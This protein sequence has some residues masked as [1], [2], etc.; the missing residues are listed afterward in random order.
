M[1]NF[2]VDMHTHSTA[3]DGTLTP[4]D[5]VALAA[6]RGVR[7]LGLCDHD[8]TA[9]LDEAIAAG[10][11]RGLTV[12]P[13]VEISTR[14]NRAKQ[15]VGLHLL[16]Y[17]ID[18]HRPRFAGLMR[19]VQEGRRQ[20]KIEQ[21]RRLQAFGLNISVEEVF[22][23]VNGVPGR[24]HIAAVLMERN[25][26]RFETVQQI[27]DEYL[28]AF[29]KAHVARPF[30][31]TVEEAIEEVRAAGGIPVLAH[32][33]GYNEATDPE[34]MVRHA[35]AAGIQGLEVYYPYASPNG[36]G[37]PAERVIARFEA[38][39]DELGLLKTGGTDFHGRPGEIRLPGD[40]GLSPAQF[41][42]IRQSR[43]G[44]SHV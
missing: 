18:H 13:G 1:A 9:G 19:E 24:P 38:L 29:K 36:A 23:R 6:R 17:F 5:L 33:G 41:D 11:K 34:A 40:A 4:A 8:T 16:G 25:P 43:A 7:V 39:A 35:A 22:S 14:H 42:L 26:G 44:A 37:D 28:G 21:I 30:A 12:I 31:L 10:R 32:P 15:F 27:Y 3:S 2:P 20:Q